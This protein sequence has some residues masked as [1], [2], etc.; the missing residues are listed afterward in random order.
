MT[1]R[2]T[3]HPARLLTAALLLSGL[4]T[5]CA[6]T[7]APFSARAYEMAVDLKVDASRVIER[8]EEPFDRHRTRVEALQVRM[9]KAVEYAR[10]RPRNEHSTRQWELMNDPDGFL[11]GG[12]LARWEAEDSLSFGFITEAGA[13]VAEGFDAIIGLESGKAGNQR[14]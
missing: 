12:F 6:P 10:G 8:A 5:A 7:I 13:L 4:L 3:P 1:Q 2:S 14:R 11:L 9:Q